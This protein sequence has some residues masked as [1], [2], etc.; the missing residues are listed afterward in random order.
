M[1]TKVKRALMRESSLRVFPFQPT[2]NDGV[3][4]LHGDVNTPDQYRRAERI[5]EQVEGVTALTNRLTMGG[6]PVTEERLARED[7]SEEASEEDTAVYHTVQAGDTLWKIARRYRSSV[8]RIRTLND[9]RS[10]DLS[11]GQR[12]RVR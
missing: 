10:D 3:L 7:D 1:E 8:E 5:A 6:R 11:P 4:I 9:L 2:V 12:L